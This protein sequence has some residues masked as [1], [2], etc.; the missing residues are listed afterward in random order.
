[1]HQDSKDSPL[2]ILDPFADKDSLLR[3][4]RHIKESQLGHEEERP[5]IIPGWHH[6]AFLLVQHYHVESQHQEC[7]FTE[8]AVCSDGY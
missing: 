8:G 1:M 2:R 7:H 5:L 3:V 4:I 6:F